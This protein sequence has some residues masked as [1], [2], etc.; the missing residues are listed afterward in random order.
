MLA[1][2]EDSLVREMTKDGRLVTVVSTYFEL[3]GAAGLKELEVGCEHEVVVV[4]EDG[5]CGECLVEQRPGSEPH[6]ARADPAASG[7]LGVWRSGAVGELTK[8]PCVCGK[9]ACTGNRLRY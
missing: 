8:L 9:L 3:P 4:D 1:N 6:F 2:L 7:V 5:A